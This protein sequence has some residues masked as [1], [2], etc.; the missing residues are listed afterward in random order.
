IMYGA[1]VVAIICAFIGWSNDMPMFMLF[2]GILV[3]IGVAQKLYLQRLWDAVPISTQHATDKMTEQQYIENEQIIQQQQTIHQELF[4]L[5]NELKKVL[6]A[7]LLLDNKWEA[8]KTKQTQLQD[9]IA[10]E[11]HQYPILRQLEGDIWDTNM[12]YIREVKEM[13][14]K[15][16]ELQNDLNSMEHT[17]DP[18]E[19]IRKQLGENLGEQN[20]KIQQIEVKYNQ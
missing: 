19:R 11:T 2:A 5:Q 18:L 13:M 12:Q 10:T 15:R 7:D 14:Q 6:H 17:F 16:E 3:I 1:I 8:W 4:L 9:K 20:I